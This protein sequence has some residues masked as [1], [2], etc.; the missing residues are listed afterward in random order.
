MTTGTKILIGV[1]VVTIVG[2]LVAS[3]M[4]KSALDTASSMSGGLP[5]DRYAGQTIEFLPRR[6]F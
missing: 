1:G 6:A 3:F 5:V 4:W 2:G